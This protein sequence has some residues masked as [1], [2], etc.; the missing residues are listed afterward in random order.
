MIE[1]R[2]G[3]LLKVARGVTSLEEVFR[4]IPSEHLNIEE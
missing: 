4:V 1:F 2:Q 3:A